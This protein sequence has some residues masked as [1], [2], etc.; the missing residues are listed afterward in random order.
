VTEF[1]GFR[2]AA[3]DTP[4]RVNPNRQPGRWNHAGSRPTQYLALHPLATWAEYLRWHD[5]RDPAAARELRLGVWAIRIVVDDV[6]AVRFDN[7]SDLG[8]TAEDLISDD[9]SGCQA[10]AERLRLERMG[11]KVLEVPSAALPGARNLVILEPRVGIPYAFEPVDPVDLPVTLAAAGG[12]P[13]ASMLPLVRFRHEPH[14][15]F[16]AWKAGLPFELREPPDALL[17][18]DAAG[19]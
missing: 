19:P 18:A 10:C 15:E 2:V 17:A 16:E 9:W 7:A 8:L 3:W 4:L 14:A 13:P 1:A 12:R 6:L 11:P 5:I